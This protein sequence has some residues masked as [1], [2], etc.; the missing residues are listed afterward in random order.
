MAQ[1]YGPIVPRPSTLTACEMRQTLSSI[2]PKLLA[3]T[4]PAVVLSSAPHSFGRVFTGAF[5]E[6]LAG[7]LRIE[8][9]GENP[10]TTEFKTVVRCAGRMLI[11]AVRD[12]GLEPAFFAP[13]ARKMVS[14]DEV[15]FDR[16]FRA[17][18]LTGFTRKGILKVGESFPRSADEPKCRAVA[19]E[20][21]PETL[22]LD[23]RRFGLNESELL[24]Q[25]PPS[26]RHLVKGVAGEKAHTIND[27]W[28]VAAETFVLNLFRRGRVELD[29]LSESLYGDVVRPP[30]FLDARRSHVIH[31]VENG[32]K[33]PALAISR[34]F[35]DA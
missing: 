15:T 24:L 12:A 10:T 28:K 19:S 23:G 22:R 4:A 8:S 31:V 6:V 20:T 30:L 1:P 14:Y 9:K 11:A 2:D 16:K 18:I 26:T 25:I 35:F 17:A 13:D 34:R 32:T 7:M 21:G 29:A 5:L 3:P 33:K 27:E